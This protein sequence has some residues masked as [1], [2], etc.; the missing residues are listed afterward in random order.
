MAVKARLPKLAVAKAGPSRSTTTKAGNA[1]P[2]ITPVVADNPVVVATPITFPAKVPQGSEVRMIEVLKLRTYIIPSSLSHKPASVAH[3]DTHNEEFFVTQVQ[4]AKAA[5]GA[6]LA[7]DLGS[8]GDDNVP[9]S[10]QHILDSNSN[11]DA[12]KHCCKKKHNTNA[13][14]LL[15][16]DAKKAKSNL[17][18]LNDTVPSHL[19]VGWEI[20]IVCGCYEHQ[21]NFRGIL[22]PNFYWSPTTNVV[23]VGDKAVFACSTEM[24]G[25]PHISPCYELSYQWAPQGMPMNPEQLWLLLKLI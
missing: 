5:T 11:N 6:S 24:V 3:W 16:I 19:P 4:A 10:E 8:N 20:M 25:I 1:K 22:H 18:C 23:F 7:L 14:R 2:A 17:K 12:N 21:N 9:T 13:K 15:A